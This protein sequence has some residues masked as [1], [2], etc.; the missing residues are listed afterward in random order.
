MLHT[1]LRLVVSTV[2]E[3]IEVRTGLV[4]PLQVNITF[5]LIVPGVRVLTGAVACWVGMVLA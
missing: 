3:V 2:M 5:S 4:Q 1:V